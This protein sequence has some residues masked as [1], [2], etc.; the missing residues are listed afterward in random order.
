VF[1][2]SCPSSHRDAYVW[3]IGIALLILKL[4]G[5]IYALA[6]SYLGRPIVS[7]EYLAGLVP[8]PVWSLWGIENLLLVPEKKKTNKNKQKAK[9]NNIL[10]KSGK[11]C[12]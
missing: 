9:S 1:T 4:R 2:G 6:S 11:V 3:D 10:Q 5:A 12:F 7:T 8:K